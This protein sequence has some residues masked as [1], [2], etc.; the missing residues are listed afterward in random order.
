MKTGPLLLLFYLLFNIYSQLNAQVFVHPHKPSTRAAKKTGKIAFAKRDDTLRIAAV[1]DIMLGTSYPDHNTLPPDGAKNSFKNAAKELRAAD[2]TFG[3]LE[4]TLLD[5]GAPAA[6]KMHQQNKA[7]LFRMPEQYGKVFKDAGF[8]VLSLANN[9][10]GDFAATG[11]TT[12]MKTLDSLGIKYGGQVS[13]P[14]AIVDVKGVKIGFCAFAP[15]S[16]TLALLNLKRARLIIAALKRQCDIVIVSFHGGGEGTAFEHVPRKMEFYIGERRGNVHDF[17]HNAIDAG[18]D[19]VLGNGPHVCRAMELYNNRLIAY[20]LGNF[21]TYRCV[22]VAGICGYAPLLK[23][24]INKKG[25][26][27]NGRLISFLQTHNKGL[28]PDELNLAARRI[29]D[30]TAADFPQTGITI[31]ANGTIRKGPL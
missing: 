30:L 8:D 20:S 1:G 18:A 16:N 7:W 29:K 12:T 26:F 4:G 6:Y 24:N 13:H 14:S 31:A 3:N 11:R 22:S 10:I 28:Q 23:V 15:N 9:H 19:L 27:L 25:E 2:V 21:C 17:A 5:A